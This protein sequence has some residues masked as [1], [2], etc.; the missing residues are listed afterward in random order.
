MNKEVRVNGIINFRQLGGLKSS[1]GQRVRENLLFRSGGLDL[2]VNELDGFLSP[3]GIRQ[4]YD[5]RSKGEILASPYKLPS[6]IEYKHRPILPSIDKDMEELGLIYPGSQDVADSSL[7]MGFSQDKLKYMTGFMMKIYQQMGEEPQVFGGIIKEFL[8]AD[9]AVL[10]HCSAG[11]D[12]TGV[13]SAMLLL[14]LGVSQDQVMNNYLLS[15]EYRQ[16]EI[17]RELEKLSRFV[18]DDKQLDKIRDTLLVKEE[19]LAATLD[20]I[21]SFGSFYGYA[22]EKLLLSDIELENLHNRYLE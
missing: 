18:K 17:N 20:K 8:E 2:S 6:H 15:N 13:L 4:V 3:L 9:T 5:L 11:K 19:Y 10:Y 22:R 7:N 21:N 16:E 1:T 14:S 12:R